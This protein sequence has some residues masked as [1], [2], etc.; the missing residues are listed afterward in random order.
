M[1]DAEEK[2][3]SPKHLFGSHTGKR[4]TLLRLQSRGCRYPTILRQN[5]RRLFK[6]T[7]KQNL[8]SRS[9]LFFIVVD[10]TNGLYPPLPAPPFGRVSFGSVRGWGSVRIGFGAQYKTLLHKGNSF[11]QSV[12]P[13][14]CHYVE[15]NGCSL[16]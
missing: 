15:S 14:N 8:D 3:S 10:D 7:H 9:V 16:V 1:R 6:Q 11:P 13:N 2:P 12:V 4:Y 5:S